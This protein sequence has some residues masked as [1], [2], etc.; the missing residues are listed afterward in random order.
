MVCQCSRYADRVLA[1][2]AKTYAW[3]SNSGI[4]T[5]SASR[6]SNRLSESPKN[7]ADHGDAVLQK[8]E[9]LDKNTRKEK[10]IERTAE[11]PLWQVRT[12]GQQE[13]EGF[14]G[15]Y[16]DDLIVFG[17]DELVNQVMEQLM[18]VFKMAEP[19]RVYLSEIGMDE[20][21]SHTISQ[22]KY[23]EELLNK[24]QGTE[25]QPLPKVTEAEG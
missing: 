14:L 19:T 11:N 8:V 1:S 17:E 5:R 7:W 16:V 13:P 23:V 12:E 10:W 15:V 18:M 2:R 9:W 3:K 24:L 21:F 6:S 22:E 20:E 4:S 25:A